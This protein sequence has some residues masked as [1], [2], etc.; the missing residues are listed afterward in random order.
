MSNFKKSLKVSFQAAVDAATSGDTVCV[1]TGVYDENVLINKPLTLLGL[2]DPQGVDAAQITVSGGTYHIAISSNDVTV[3]GL[4]I[5]GDGF[6]ATGHYAGI[7]VNTDINNANLSRINIEGNVVTELST[8]GGSVKGIHLHNENNGLFLQ[9]SD[10]VVKDNIVQGILGTTSGAYGIQMVNDMDGV[11]IEDNLIEDVT[12]PGWAFG[13][14]VDCHSTVPTVTSV[15]ILSNHIEVT[16]GVSSAA[17]LVES[18]AFASTININENNILTG[19]ANLGSQELN[20]QSNWWGSD[21]DLVFSPNI[22]GL[23]DYEPWATSQFSIYPNTQPVVCEGTPDECSSFSGQYCEEMGCDWYG[24][25]NDLDGQI[26]EGEEMIS[27]N[28]DTMQWYECILTVEPPQIDPEMWHGQYF[29]SAVATDLDGL[30]DEFAE[31][32]YWFFNPVVSLG[33]TGD[34]NFGIVRPG[35]TVISDPVVVTNAAEVGSGVLLDMFIAGTD[36]YDPTHSGATCPISNVLRLMENPGTIDETGFRYYATS[37]AYNTCE[38]PGNSGVLAA[39]AQC[40]V[41]IPYYI[42]GAG[43]SGNNNFQRIIAQNTGGP[44]FP[45]NVLSPG[46]NMVLNFKLALPE[47][48]NGGPFSDGEFK[49]FGEAI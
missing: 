1:D 12:S 34:V 24:G 16:Q 33:I 6:V 15:N 29:V 35:A 2:N 42:G 32:E 43:D 25:L 7:I 30:W 26:F 31:N 36:F 5:D 21:N 18:C 10:T 17:V 45:G 49:F 14:A 20:A 4:R 13:V 3:K 23:V 37:G 48:C 11:T 44:Y 9:I 38:H 8:T 27:W 19:L 40:Y 39:D 28:V 47:P 22:F 46:A 41:G